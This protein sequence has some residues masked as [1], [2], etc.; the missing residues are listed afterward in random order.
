MKGAER[1]A[2]R[3]L[4]EIE[5]EL[6]SRTAESSRLRQRFAKALE[7]AGP[8]PWPPPPKQDTEPGGN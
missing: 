3:R 8:A 2:L 5:A 4:R 7:P 6:D 1:D